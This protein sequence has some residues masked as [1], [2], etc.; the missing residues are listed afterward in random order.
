MNHPTPASPSSSNDPN[1]QI[2][3]AKKEQSGRL[4]T[5]QIAL[6]GSLLSV[7][8]GMAGAAITGWFSKQSEEIK[9]GTSINLEKLKFETGLVI[10]AIKTDDQTK[11]VKTL[12][13]FANAG[14]IPTFEK[15]VL[16]LTETDNGSGVPALEAIEIG[17]PTKI[18]D[19]AKT[20]LLSNLEKYRDYMR[21]IGYQIPAT[22]LNIKFDPKQQEVTLIMRPAKIVLS[23][24]LD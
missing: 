19:I 13:F 8:S 1:D 24:I 14:L 11:A 3:L 16:T 20:T 10:Q 4:T 15:R 9:G 21:E 18:S 7:V 22:K 12:K 17:G 23:W 2:E 6:L 5:S